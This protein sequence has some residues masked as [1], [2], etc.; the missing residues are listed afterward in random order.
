M[1]LMKISVICVIMIL[2]S[3]LIG[4]QAAAHPPGFVKPKYK[5]NSLKVT[6][7]HFS[8]SPFRSHYVYKIE[9][10]KNGQD[11]LVETYEKQP[12]FIFFSYVYTVEAEVGDVL[13]VTTY[14]SLFGQKS[15][16]ITV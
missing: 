14:C 15:K 13:T 6:I 2:I 5:E 8:I 4:V 16:T 7:I 12:R 9:I 10:E 3:L 11:Y 1:K